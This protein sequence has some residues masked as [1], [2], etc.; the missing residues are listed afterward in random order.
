MVNVMDGAPALIRN[1]FPVADRTMVLKLVGRRSNRDG[2]GALVRV[3][4]G[5]HT[6]IRE[7]R[8]DRGYL[9]HSDSRLYIGLGDL[10]KIDKLTIQWPGGGRDELVDL[11]RESYTVVQGLGIV[12]TQ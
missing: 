11:G 7:V 1:G 10:A 9:S 4:M 5:D 6:A 3:E 2:V 8:G 12:A